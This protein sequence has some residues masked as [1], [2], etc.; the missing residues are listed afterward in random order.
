MFIVRSRSAAKAFIDIARYTLEGPR[1]VELIESFS[2]TPSEDMRALQNH[3]DRTLQA[4]Q[5]IGAACC[6][7]PRKGM[8]VA[9]DVRDPSIRAALQAMTALYLETLADDEIGRCTAEIDIAE[10][11]MAVDAVL[12]RVGHLRPECMLMHETVPM[13]EAAPPRRVAPKRRSSTLKATAMQKAT[14][15]ELARPDVAPQE[16]LLQDAAPQDLAPQDAAPQDPAP[17]PKQRRPRRSKV[18]G[19]EQILTG[20]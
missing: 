20:V 16:A 1:L 2:P 7:S 9:I 3:V 15:Q 18:T 5:A 8:L 4:A 17:M 12:D 13:L 19:S 10:I 6:E 11:R 14:R